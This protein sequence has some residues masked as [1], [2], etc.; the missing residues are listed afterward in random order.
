MHLRAYQCEPY[1]Y[2]LALLHH[3]HQPIP[4]T[5]GT[6]F[7][8]TVESDQLALV[9]SLIKLLPQKNQNKG[10]TSSSSILKNIKPSI[11]LDLQSSICNSKALVILTHSA[12]TTT[13]VQTLLDKQLKFIIFDKESELWTHNLTCTNTNPITYSFSL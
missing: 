3:P 4:R 7:A 13:R 8:V 9:I 11:I 10:T 1:S 12:K 5:N 6:N 2:L